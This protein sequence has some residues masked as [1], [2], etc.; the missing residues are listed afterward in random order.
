MALA[1]LENVALANLTLH[2][3]VRSDRPEL[4]LCN[5]PSF[6]FFYLIESEEGV[7]A[8]ELPFQGIEENLFRAVLLRL[9]FQ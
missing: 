9:T 6:M 7:P 4:S 2:V 1:C 8:N 5:F 3:M